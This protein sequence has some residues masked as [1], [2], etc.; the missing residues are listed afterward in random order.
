MNC[1]VI[2]PFASDFDDV[3]TTIKTSLGAI[4][5]SK[6][7][8][9]MRLDEARPAG[10]ITDRLLHELEAAGLCIA[11]VTGNRPNVMWEVGYAMALGKPVILIT[12]NVDELPFD[13]RDLQSLQY[14]RR[15]LSRTLGEPLRRIVLDT[16]D[17]QPSPRRVATSNDR[18]EMVGTLLTELQ[19]LKSIISDLVTTSG[20]GYDLGST[21][22]SGG[23]AVFVGAWVDRESGSYLY[24]RIVGGELVIPYCWNGNQD[25]TGVYFGCRKTGDHWFAR[26]AWVSAEITGYAF[27]RQEALDRMSGA[28]WHESLNA[29]PSGPPAQAGVSV[30]LERVSPSQEPAWATQFFERVGKGG[31][32]GEIAR[33]LRAREHYDPERLKAAGW[34]RTSRAVDQRSKG[35]L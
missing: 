31:L 18:D 4:L 12:E 33:A 26:F 27:L 13:I 35:K 20:R 11:D 19:G 7:G 24:A 1:F 16:M 2:M 23:P 22:P 30:R 21:P 5:S 14:D 17:G 9:C 3:Y 15:H 32:A 28:W 34:A 29:D 10:R 25:L 8:S 6:G